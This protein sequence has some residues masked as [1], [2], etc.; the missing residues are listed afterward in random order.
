[1][2]K[3]ILGIIIIILGVILL[4]NTLTIWDI[5]IFFRG[6][7]T[8]FIIIPSCFG[9][10]EKD[11]FLPSVISLLIGVLLL[12]ACQ[13]II[14]WSMIWKLFVPIVFILIGLVIIFGGAKRTK[15]VL[16]NSKEYIAIFSGVKE[17]IREVKTN[18]SVIA[19]FGSVDLDLRDAK[20][21]EDIVIDCVSIFGGID[22]KLPSNVN[23]E[24]SGVP[25]FGGA[26]NKTK[27]KETNKITVT[28]NYVSV[29]GGVSLI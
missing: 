20:I 29:F 1:M 11:D 2:K 7:W 27:S 28:I 18:F 3:T 25:I 10:T 9:L 5:D 13:S 12:L 16:E 22:I 17:E 8:L 26:E 21:K 23:V 14:T 24:T 19:I 15:R 6:W 4:G